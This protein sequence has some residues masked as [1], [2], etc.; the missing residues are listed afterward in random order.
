[1]SSPEPIFLLHL[2]GVKMGI[3]S[4]GCSLDRWMFPAAG[5]RTGR[6][7][8]RRPGPEEARSHGL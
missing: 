8:D 6:E 3:A 5:T 7:T 1:M 2:W 4:Y